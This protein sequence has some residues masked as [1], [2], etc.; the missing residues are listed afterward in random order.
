MHITI[1]NGAHWGDEGK[2]KI[3][4]YLS[5]QTDVSV[6]CNGGS[7]AGHQVVIGNESISFRMLPIGI[8]NGNMGL[9]TGEVVLGCDWLLRDIKIAEEKLGSISERLLISENAH[10][11]LPQHRQRDTKLDQ[12]S[13]KIGTTKQGIGPAISDRRSRV[14]V[15]LKSFLAG[16]VGSFGP[17]P[18]I[19][20]EYRQ[21]LQQYAGSTNEYFAKQKAQKKE[22]KILIESGQGFMLDN[23][24]GT[25]PFVTSS[26]TSS[27]G[28]LHG[29]GLPVTWLKRNIAVTK[30]Y[31]T[32]YSVGPFVARCE[33]QQEQQLREFG[34]EYG[35]H[36]RKPMLCGW[37]DLVALRYAQHV[38]HYTELC[39]NKLDVLSPYDEIPVC[40]GYKYKG[41]IL[42][43]L[44]EWNNLDQDAYQPVYKVLKGW[45]KDI[46]GLQSF[47]ELPPEAQDYIKFIEDAVEV[48]VTLIGTGPKNNDVIDRLS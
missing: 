2:G 43:T 10:V 5:Q 21:V 46:S 48:P 17:L 14:G 25:Y 40:V 1:V 9:I 44:Y 12:N 32:R 26:H 7:N 34:N 33:P 8:V 29:A 41:Q 47:A 18:D 4:H 20:Q 45:R 13:L 42:D 38:N 6:R 3:C 24:H 15:D 35:N 30:A 23:T 22:L 11:V 39:I 31:V 37:F 27:A 19:Y 16:N 36:S 28:L